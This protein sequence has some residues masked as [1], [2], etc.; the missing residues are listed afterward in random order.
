MANGKGCMSGC[1][2]VIGI[3]V[4]LGVIG[5]MFG[6]NDSKEA[7]KKEPTTQEQV[8]TVEKP[9]VRPVEQKTEDMTPSLTI[10]AA[11]LSRA[12]HD[13]ELKAKDSYKGLVAE[14]TGVVQSV[15]EMFGQKFIVLDGDT[16][17]PENIVS[18]QCF[19][20]KDDNV[21][22]RAMEVSKGSTITIIGKIGEQ[23]INVGVDD[24]IIK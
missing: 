9:K 3:I 12:F 7:S 14:I 18:I 20:A 15:D 6:G 8:R 16:D 21:V 4:I 10:S 19:L 24:C 13:N 22:R 2:S 1:L 5:S 11:E 17:N 23:S